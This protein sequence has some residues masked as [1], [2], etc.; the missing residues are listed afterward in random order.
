M[1]GEIVSTRDIFTFKYSGEGVYRRHIWTEPVASR[2]H[3]Q[4]SATWARKAAA[5]VCGYYQFRHCKL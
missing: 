4:G 1:E 2:S 3:C 5:R